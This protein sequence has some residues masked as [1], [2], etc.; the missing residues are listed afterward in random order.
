METKLVEYQLEK[1]EVVYAL[2]HP[3]EYQQ[4]E[5]CFIEEG[6]CCLWLGIFDGRFS[7]TLNYNY[8]TDGEYDFRE[9]VEKTVLPEEISTVKKTEKYLNK[10]LK[11]IISKCKC[12]S[13]ELAEYKE[14]VYR[15]FEKCFD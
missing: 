6:N 1:E 3:E 15:E 12:F 5:L 14:S 9:V 11:K 4:E 8:L 13:Y 2:K 7:L 10:E